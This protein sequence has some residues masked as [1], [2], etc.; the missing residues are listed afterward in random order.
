MSTVNNERRIKQYIIFTSAPKDLQNKGYK[1]INNYMKDPDTN[2]IKLA[3]Q[4]KALF[5]DNFDKKTTGK[6]IKQLGYKTKPRSVSNINTR[7][8]LDKVNTDRHNNSVTSGSLVTKLLKQMQTIGMTKEQFTNEWS[9][10]GVKYFNDKYGFPQYHTELLVQH[11]GLNLHRKL[12]HTWRDALFQFKQVGYTEQDI[13]DYIIN[14][15]HTITDAERW[16][17][18]IV[19]W[20]IGD[21]RF[22]HIRKGINFKLTSKQIASRQGKKSRKEK[23]AAYAR[24]KRSG[25][26]INSLAKEYENDVTMTK[27]EVLDVINAPLKLNEPEFTNRWLT[28][29]LDPLLTDVRKGSVSRE[30]L[31]FRTTFEALHPEYTVISNDRT[32]LP[33]GRELD[34]YI[35]ELKLA[36]EFNGDYWHSDKFMLTNHDETANE[37]HQT[38]LDE[39]KK[40]GI[41]LL[42]VWESAWT[43]QKQVIVR[44]IDDFIQRKRVSK[45]LTLLSNENNEL[46][47]IIGK[48]LNYYNKLGKLIDSKMFLSNIHHRKKAY[49]QKLA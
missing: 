11:F 28:R 22:E 4:M 15:H 18:D 43:T 17:S 26:T 10:H 41:Q 48:E 40:A 13:I 31:N 14:Q 24:L 27:E 29:H 42:F 32:I 38:K 35:P 34:M 23:A 33:D 6:M 45:V 19:G 30:E 44:A 21:K 20:K 1:L 46:D 5:N 8:A 25:Y 2:L 39:C 9:N 37:Y 12:T 36:I 47:F 7:K 49:L 3:E 16:F